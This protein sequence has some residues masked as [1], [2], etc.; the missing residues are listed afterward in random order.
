MGRPKGSK[1]KSPA[2]KAKATAKKPASKTTATRKAKKNTSVPL[3][4]AAVRE[5]EAELLENLRQQQL[6]KGQ[7]FSNSKEPPTIHIVDA[8]CGT[9]KT[10]AAIN[11]INN[12]LGH[13]EGKHFM[14]V[15]PTLSEVA[16]IKAECPHANFQEPVASNEYGSKYV[17]VL[18]SLVNGENIVTTHSLFS[19]FSANTMKV[20]RQQNYILILDEVCEIIQQYDKGV[21]DA[22]I[23][24]QTC[25]KVEEDGRLVW[26]RENYEDR[27]HHNETYLEEQALCETGSLYLYKDNGEQSIFVWLFP[28][29]VFKNFQEIFILTYMFDGQLQAYY[30]KYFSIPFTPLYVE[31]TP[32][33]SPYELTNKER[34]SQYHFTLTPQNYDVPNLSELIEIYQGELNSVGDIATLS[35][36][37]YWLANTNPKFQSASSKEKYLMAQ[38]AFAQLKNNLYN[39]FFQKTPTRDVNLVMWTTFKDY[40]KKL[41]GKG[42]ASESCFVPCNARAT[43]DYRDRAYLAYTTNIYMK[44]MIK[45]FFKKNKVEIDEDLFALSELIQWLYRSRIRCGEKVWIYIPVERMRWLLQE[46]ID[47]NGDFTRMRFYKRPQPGMTREQEDSINAAIE[48]FIQGA[49]SYEK[50]EVID[51]LN[52]D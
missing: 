48:A 50:R 44:P 8:P 41:K 19:Y 39:Y 13:F 20:C 32:V 21:D 3:Q 29:E 26:I 5:Y 12:S 1:N 46:Y 47:N 22:D 15:T 14:Y 40:R 43:N 6:A 37:W 36:S 18:K 16:R 38:E 25:V 24:L 52:D 28:I 34:N 4:S 31:Y 33:Y 35:K 23:F 49:T 27:S 11:Y 17:S 10:S 45:Q 42:F 9:G 7:D 30:Y 2:E 51:I